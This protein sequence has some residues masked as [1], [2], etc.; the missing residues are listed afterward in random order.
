MKILQICLSSSLGG[1]ELYFLENTLYLHK[2]QNEYQVAALVRSG[3]LLHDKIRENGVKHYTWHQQT[4]KFP[5]LSAF[6]IKSLLSDNQFDV[7]H[8]HC[9]KDLPLAAWLKTFMGN[10]FKLVHTRQMN[11]PGSKKSAYHN[12]MYSQ[13]D[14]LIAITQ[15][16][17]KDM[18]SRVKI[19]AAKVETLYYG[20]EIPNRFS[21]NEFQNW[22][23]QFE[24][25]SVSF[26]MAV[27]GNLNSTKAQHNILD[28]LAL[29]QNQLESN[30]KLYLVGKF[31]DENYRQIIEERIVSNKLENRVVVTGFVENAKRW[32]PGFDLIVLTTLGETFGLVLVEAMK[33]G[34][35]VIGTNSEGVPEIIEQM[36]T[37]ILVEP[38]DVSELSRAILKLYKDETLRNNLA[39]AGKR[40]ADKVFDY[41]THFK[42]LMEIYGSFG[43]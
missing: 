16:L 37:G 1:L 8:I 24:S 27:F 31:I 11:M 36:E 41:E 32:M 2:F 12:F 39:A 35:A 22:T 7:V 43:S 19:D 25:D 18:L 3:T 29:I 13:I 4:G 30:W 34:A 26:R 17:H 20:V 6:R 42:R 28:A 15:K 9:K 23:N 5:I 40:K 38:N 14:K 10:Q 21:D 33:S